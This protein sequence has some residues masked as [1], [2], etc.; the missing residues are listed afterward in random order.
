MSE[1]LAI[2]RRAEELFGKVVVDEKVFVEKFG[3]YVVVA[4]CEVEKANERAMVHLSVEQ[5]EADDWWDVGAVMLAGASARV[6]PYGFGRTTVAAVFEARHT[7]YARVRVRAK[8]CELRSV[9]L[10]VL[11]LA[12]ALKDAYYEKWRDGKFYVA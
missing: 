8:D 4:I 11:P 2:E 5:E 1:I 3:R 10:V 7:D 12:A 6:L 9:R